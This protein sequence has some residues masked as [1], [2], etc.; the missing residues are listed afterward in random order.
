MAANVEV[1]DISSNIFTG[2][3]SKPGVLKIGKEGDQFFLNYPLNPK[4]VE[5]ILSGIKFKRVYGP[6]ADKVYAEYLRIKNLPA[7]NTKKNAGKGT[8][9]AEPKK[10][11]TSWF[12]RKKNGAPPPPASANANAAAAKAKANANAAAAKAKANA[13]AAAAKAKANA[14]AAAA[15]P[16]SPGSLAGESVVVPVASSPTAARN[17]A[18]IQSNLNT[19]K[20]KLTSY[21]TDEEAFKRLQLEEKK[22]SFLKRRKNTALQKEVEVERTKLQTNI[23]TLEKELAAAAAAAAA[24]GPPPPRSVGSIEYDIQQAEKKITEI[25]GTNNTAN[26]PKLLED[27]RAIVT[28]LKEELAAAKAAASEA[29]P[30]ASLPGESVLVPAGTSSPVV[31]RPV[32]NI[33][34]NINAAKASITSIEGTTIVGRY[35][36]DSGRKQKNLNVAKAKLAAFERERNDAIKALPPGSRVAVVASPGGL[37]SPSSPSP[38]LR[39]GLEPEAGSSPLSL[40]EEGNELSPEE[41]AEEEQR[42][43]KNK[44]NAAKREARAAAK[45]APRENVSAAGL[46]GNNTG[47]FENENNASPVARS[48]E[49]LPAPESLGQAQGPSAGGKRRSRRKARHSKKSKKTQKKRR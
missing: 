19:A 9:S 39:A 28:K 21:G 48:T 31:R 34:R 11:G 5:E 3:L 40:G 1:K 24:V 30:A 37:V 17:L 27:A 25:E 4:K 47:S 14:N 23:S 46:F 18:A 10:S 15:S 44:N 8:A 22:K 12:S 42:K 2:N 7:N 49:G 43:Q 36:A 32:N 38:G 16:G 26:K 45:A 41:R 29:S 20:A 35:D 13:N 33:Q 6:T